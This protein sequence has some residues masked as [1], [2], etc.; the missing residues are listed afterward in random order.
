[1]KL[2]TRYFCLPEKITIFVVVYIS[3]CVILENLIVELVKVFLHVWLASM[4]YTEEL[5]NKIEVNDL[6]I[7]GTKKETSKNQNLLDLE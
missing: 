1:M 7:I 6:K 3:T 4:Q 5:E 2:L